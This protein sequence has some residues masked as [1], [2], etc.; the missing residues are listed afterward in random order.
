MAKLTSRNILVSPFYTFRDKFRQ[1]FKPFQQNNRLVKTTMFTSGTS[2]GL[3]FQPSGFT[4]QLG[5][6]RHSCLSGFWICMIIHVF[7]SLSFKWHTSLNVSCEQRTTT[8]QRFLFGLNKLWFQL[9][10]CTLAFIMFAVISS[11]V[12]GCWRSKRVGKPTPPPRRPRWLVGVRLVPAQ[13]VVVLLD[14]CVRA[15]GLL[16]EH[17]CVHACMRLTNRIQ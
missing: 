9:F 7:V 2:W 15:S 6:K 5:L 13:V 4:Q 11:R 10:L 17:V 14:L 16:R 12:A 3:R 1:N 8:I